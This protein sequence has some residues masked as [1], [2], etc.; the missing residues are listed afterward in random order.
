MMPR[1][2][3]GDKPNTVPNPAVGVTQMVTQNLED[4]RA[5]AHFVQLPFRQKGHSL[6][7]KG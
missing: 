3:V 5:A 6:F 7:K 1:Q 2:P 4:E